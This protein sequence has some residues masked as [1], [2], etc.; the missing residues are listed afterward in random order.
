MKKRILAIDDALDILD[1]VQA[2]LQQEG[3][4]V[5][6]ATDGH[7][8]LEQVLITEPD[9][10]LLDLSMPVMN[11][12]EF[13]E[14]FRQRDQQNRPIPIILLTA[15]KLTQNE[16]ERLGVAGYLQKPFRQKELLNKISGLLSD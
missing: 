5:V 2:V 10:I 7:S 9:L 6:A 16:I 8:A 4:K 15:H 11:G 14:Q 3:Y 1:L 13:L 12:Y